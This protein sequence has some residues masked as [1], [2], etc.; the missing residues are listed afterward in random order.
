MLPISGSQGSFFPNG[1]SLV[2]PI[3][4]APQLNP[5]A[6]P[7]SSAS[8][9][10]GLIEL[11]RPPLIPHHQLSAPPAA[12]LV[13]TPSSGAG[14]ANGWPGIGY[15]SGVSTPSPYG[16]SNGSLTGCGGGSAAGNGSSYFSSFDNNNNQYQQQVGKWGNLRQTGNIDPAIF[17]L[18]ART[19]LPV[20]V[21]EEKFKDFKLKPKALTD[22]QKAMNGEPTSYDG[23]RKS[24]YRNRRPS[25]VE[26]AFC[27]NNGEDEVIYKSH[28]LK[29]PDGEVVCPVLRL[30][31]CP[32]CN[33]GGGP[34]AHTIRYCPK[35]RPG[36]TGRGG[37]YRALAMSGNGGMMN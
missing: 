25:C 15:W 23:G 5:L 17:T 8:P 26:C 11:R 18:D 20:E 19:D 1:Y 4:V 32:I 2:T 10:P 24:R 36:I 9:T 34:K 14:G 27:R 31:N 37:L 30:Y 35:N 28:V 13:N 6:R 3:S 7:F 21:L 12:S 16:G 29:N 33:N 22:R